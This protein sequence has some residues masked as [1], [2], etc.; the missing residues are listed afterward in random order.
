M[1]TI[2]NTVI[3]CTAGGKKDRPPLTARETQPSHRHPIPNPKEKGCLSWAPCAANYLAL[4]L[5]LYATP[6]PPPLP[7]R[8]SSPPRHQRGRAAHNN[9]RRE[10]VPEDAERDDQR[11]RG[12]GVPQV[13]RRVQGGQAGPPDEPAEGGQCWC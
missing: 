2:L 10:T 4:L 1:A 8:D 5:F 7:V 6:L 3:H 11:E 13:H 9:N 12:N